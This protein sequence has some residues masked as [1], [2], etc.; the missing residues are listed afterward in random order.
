LWCQLSKSVSLTQKWLPA[1][2]C[3]YSETFCT[4]G[5]IYEATKRRRSPTCGL[6]T[7]QPCHPRPCPILSSLIVLFVKLSHRNGRYRR[8]SRRGF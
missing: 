2:L 3:C 6:H 5:L 1:L 7:I 4:S 8:L